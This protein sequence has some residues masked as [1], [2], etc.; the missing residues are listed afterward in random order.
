M[1]DD[2]TKPNTVLTW[3][4]SDLCEFH[5]LPYCRPLD[6]NKNNNIENLTV[7][8]VLSCNMT[9]SPIGPKLICWLEVTMCGPM[10]LRWLL[11]LLT[12][13]IVSFY[14]HLLIK[15]GP[16]KSKIYFI[17][18]NTKFRFALPEIF[19]LC[20]DLLNLPLSGSTEC[21]TSLINTNV[22]TVMDARLDTLNVPSMLGRLN[23]VWRPRWI[24]RI[25]QFYVLVGLYLIRELKRLIW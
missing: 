1:P 25:F 20:L 13:K 3:N 5:L 11:L 23:T 15:N 24:K 2:L 8:A 14:Y 16:W 19:T 9:M 12:F 21:P 22:A 7:M 4:F 18:W 17:I 6:I 10:R